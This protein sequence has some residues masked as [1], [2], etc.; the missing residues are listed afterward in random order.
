MFLQP[1][2][3]VTHLLDWV[4]LQNTS[5]TIIFSLTPAIR[6]HLCAWSPCLAHPSGSCLACPPLFQELFNCPVPERR[7]TLSV[8]LAE[9]LALITVRATSNLELKGTGRVLLELQLKELQHHHRIHLPRPPRTEG[10]GLF[11]WRKFP[12]P[13]WL[14]GNSGC[15]LVLLGARVLCYKSG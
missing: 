5:V 4:T 11:L 10:R 3:N 7:S 9:F 8:T 6:R 12:Y 1:T 14:E 15:S 13:D 2:T